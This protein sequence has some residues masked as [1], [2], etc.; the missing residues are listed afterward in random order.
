MDNSRHDTLIK[1]DFFGFRRDSGQTPGLHNL[2]HS[3]LLIVCREQPIKIFKPFVR[4]TLIKR[5]LA[6]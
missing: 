4:D 6:P 1:S 2:R 3:I 5:R